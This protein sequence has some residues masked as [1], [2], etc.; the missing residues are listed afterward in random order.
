MKPIVK[1]AI[2]I[3]I[4]AILVIILNKSYG[5]VK[6]VLN[7]PTNNKVIVIDA[8]HGGRDG[9]ASGRSGLKEKD[10]NLEIAKKLKQYIEMNGG[11]A[12]M[13]REED[14]GLYSMET[15]NKKREDMKNRKEIIKE[16]GADLLISIHLNSF[17]QAKYYGAQVFYFEGSKPSQWLAKVMQQELR[18]V[19]DKNNDR[20]EKSTNSY[21]ILKDNDIPSILVECGFLSNEEEERLLSQPWYQEKIAWSLYVGMLKYFTEPIPSI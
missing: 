21:F 15:S 10:V 13:I 9:G 8:G 3:L 16:S 2:A 7:I 4:T 5:E 14:N 18:R 6:K 20:V 19:L 12:V 11:V 17:P 1:K